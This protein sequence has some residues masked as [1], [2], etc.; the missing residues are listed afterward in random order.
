MVNKKLAQLRS[1]VK[2][3]KIK[4][5]KLIK[6]KSSASKTRVKPNKGMKS[7]LKNKSSRLA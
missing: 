4:R 3:N 6:T 1:R 5:T 2:K 7:R